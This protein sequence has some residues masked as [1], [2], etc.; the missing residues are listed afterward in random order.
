MILPYAPGRQ[1][2]V[3]ASGKIIERLARS[4]LSCRRSIH[5]PY[6]PGMIDKARYGQHAQPA[7]FFPHRQTTGSDTAQ[8]IY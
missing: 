1:I 7:A 8:N 6:L 3:G 4:R 5:S 2:D